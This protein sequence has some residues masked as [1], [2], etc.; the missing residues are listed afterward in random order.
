MQRNDFSQKHFATTLA[1]LLTVGGIAFADMKSGDV[2]PDLTKFK[3]EGNLPAS[4]K[5]K[6]VL[7]DFWASWCVPCKDS[8]PC[9][10]ELHKKYADRGLVIIA[11]NVDEKRT[12]MDVFLKTHPASFTVVRDASEKLVD[13]TGIGTMPSSFL[14]DRAGKVRYLHTGYHGE[15]TKKEYVTEIESL[16]A[17]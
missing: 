7:V 12:D 8:F 5:D 1:L 11:I 14:I 2:F 6:I 13:L 3:L 15:P 9:M 4:L 16:L 17:K 10:N